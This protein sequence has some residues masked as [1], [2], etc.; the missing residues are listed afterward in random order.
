M[1]Q[2]RSEEQGFGSRPNNPP[3]NC[4]LHTEPNM[5]ICTKTPEELSVLPVLGFLGPRALRAP[6][7]DNSAAG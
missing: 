1:E 7:P 6:S 5:R 2:S 3:Q 4:F